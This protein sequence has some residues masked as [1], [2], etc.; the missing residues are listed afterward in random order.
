ML[1]DDYN[2]NVIT[3]DDRD[4]C[5]QFLEWYDR[6]QGDLLGQK[7]TFRV[8]P[9]T[10][11][12]VAPAYLVNKKMGSV[13]LCAIKHE[14]IT[15]P[16][17]QPE[18]DELHCE[19]VEPSESL[20]VTS[21]DSTIQFLLGDRSKSIRLP[22]MQRHDSL[23]T[24]IYKG[25]D[26]DTS[27]T[28]PT[29]HLT[30]PPMTASIS[31]RNVRLSPESFEH[32][33][34]KYKT[35]EILDIRVADMLPMVCQ[36]EHVH[37]SASL[38]CWVASFPNCKTLK[39]HLDVLHLDMLDVPVVESVYVYGTVTTPGEYIQVYSEVDHAFNND[40]SNVQCS[41]SFGGCDF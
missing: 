3:V 7:V 27:P 22:E 15:L 8:N 5:G 30:H 21:T 9:Y 37:I 33:L 40:T 19:F 4:T 11:N 10:W 16:V 18:C 36:A 26:D 24:I 32:I 35:I 1:T 39:I 20:Q 14:S 23:D 41:I 13:T 38:L 2:D 6:H 34:T 28:A 12:R 17:W 25:S 31:V 29:V